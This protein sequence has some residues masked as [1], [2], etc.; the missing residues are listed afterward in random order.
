MVSAKIA[1][2]TTAIVA[3]AVAASFLAIGPMLLTPQQRSSETVAVT[4]GLLGEV[5]HRLTGGTVEVYQILPPGAE[6]HDWEPT[7]DVVEKVRTSR[8]LFWT[9]EGFDDW[10]ERLA[11]SAQVKAFKVSTWVELLPYENEHNH[12]H[13]AYDPH[14]WLDPRRFATVVQ[15]MAQILSQEFPEKRETIQRNSEAY[16]QEIL[17]LNQEYEEALSKHQGK[18]FITQH[19]AFRYL[20]HAFGLKAVAVLSGE[21]EEPSAA[22]LAEIYE[23]VKRE[24]IR[25]VFA[26]EGNI[27]PILETMA[28]DLGVEIKTLYT[29]ESLLTYD[30]QKGQGYIV[31]MR[32]NLLTLVDAFED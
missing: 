14:F 17:Q 1:L 22:H 32:Q 23:L 20:A 29:M 9:V 21:E 16:I 10:G 13:G 11:A 24:R 15:N 30:Y 19:N 6:I 18:T 5:V 25:V 26:E 12:D 31:R 28:S 4:W 8:M 3:I 2:L 7:P 27:S